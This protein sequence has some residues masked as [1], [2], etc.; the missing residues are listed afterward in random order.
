[1]KQLN[2]TIE[3]HNFKNQTTNKSRHKQI[4]STNKYIVPTQLKTKTLK[5]IKSIENG[6]DQLTLDDI[7]VDIF[8][9]A[10]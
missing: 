3:H 5:R 6:Q 1:L 4:Q 10:K 2:G 7:E 9:R 8:T